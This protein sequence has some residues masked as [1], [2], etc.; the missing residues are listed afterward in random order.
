MNNRVQ[1]Q[2]VVSAV[3]LLSLIAGWNISQAEEQSVAGVY[4]LVEVDGER[5]PANSWTEN[6]DGERCRQVILK[7][8]L[9]L[10]SEG[11]SSAFLTER[12]FC[13]SEDASENGGKEQSV[14]FAGTYAVSRNQQNAL[15]NVLR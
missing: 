12:V 7:G 2:F 6:L 9:L 14:I 10:D 11:R 4:S 3:A 13:P 5:L 1:R 8:V 15:L